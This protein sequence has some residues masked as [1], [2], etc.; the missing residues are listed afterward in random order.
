MTELM[1]DANGTGSLE[2]LGDQLGV[3][4]DSLKFVQIIILQNSCHTE[5]VKSINIQFGQL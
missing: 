3:R 1:E 2:T 4:M 5:L